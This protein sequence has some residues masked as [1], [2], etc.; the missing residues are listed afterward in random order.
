MERIAKTAGE[1]AYSR[2]T[3]LRRRSRERYELALLSSC[4]LACLSLCLR[5]REIT[6]RTFYYTLCELPA[7]SLGVGAEHFT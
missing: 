7:L 3:T 6:R 4:L 2:L 5:G 1:A